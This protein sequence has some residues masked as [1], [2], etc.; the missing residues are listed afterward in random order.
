MGAFMTEKG[1]GDLES[2]I[3]DVMSDGSARGLAIGITDGSGRILYERYFGYRDEE[4]RL[5]IDRD[6][7]FGMAS[8]TKSFTALSIMQMQADGLLSVTDP[9]SKY[10]PGFSGMNNGEPVLIWHL[11]CHSGGYFPLPRIVVD[12]TAKEMGIEDTLSDELIYRDDFAD[13][14]VRLVASRL[15][16]QT[17]FTGRPGERLSYCND[18]FG[19]LS[20]IIR[21]HSGY[22]SF[23][24]YLENRILGPLKMTR[25]NIS[26]IRNTLDDNAAVL[27]SLE[28]GKWRADR[29]YQNDA[30]VLHGGGAL[31]STLS[32][33]LKYAVMYLNEG[34]SADGMRII[35]RYSIH[36]M[37]KPRQ[38]MKPGVYYGYGLESRM[39]GDMTVIEHTGSLPGVSSSFSFSPEA[40]LGIVVLCNTMD[41]AVSAIA[42]AAMNVALGLPAISPRPWHADRQWSE[43]EM[44]ELEGSYVSGE[45]DSFILSRSNGTLAMSLN[46]SDIG[47]KAIY[48]WQGMV[49]KKYSD[50]YLTPIRDENGKVFA[51][52]YGSRIFPKTGPS[53]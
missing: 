24:S 46:G 10:I 35:D 40:Q 19:L 4:R 13:E 25:S 14:G 32:D 49:R 29:D 2:I 23:A 42:D 15:D 52:Q 20:D 53:A 17:R 21:R 12:K 26:F 50:V 43:E 28:E 31:K 34:V 39:I 51:A 27:Y 7:I 37:E 8:V 30:F 22:G 5:P 11:M 6:T 36:E 1:L 44:A 48:P 18:G 47:L 16:A 41:V 33:M 38:V 3:S 9:V 45:G